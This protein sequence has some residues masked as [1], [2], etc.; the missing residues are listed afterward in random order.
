MLVSRYIQTYI[1]LY[2]D[3][4]DY[5]NRRSPVVC[6]GRVGFDRGRIELLQHIAQAGSIS[7]AAWAMEMSY[8]GGLNG[9]LFVTLL[10]RLMHRRRRLLH[11]VVDGLPAHKTG[12]VRDY[13]AGLDGKPTLHL[14][15]GYAPE[16]NPDERIWNHAKRTGNAR[17]PLRKGEK[18][19]ERVAAQLADMGKT[20]A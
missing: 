9:E 13:V 11:L 19:E 6:C 12:L 1:T 17:R 14:L 4:A 10:R 8:K 7:Q 5:E 3:K 18:L 15:P 20:P 2:V 16:L